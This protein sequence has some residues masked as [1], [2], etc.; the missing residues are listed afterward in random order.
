MAVQARIKPRQAR[1]QQLQQRALELR[2]ARMSYRAIG[3]ELG[4]SHAWARALCEH[5]FR[6]VAERIRAD[7][8][9]ELGSI[10][11]AQDEALAVLHREMTGADT[12]ADRSRAATAFARVLHDRA[13]MLG[14]SAPERTETE[15]M[16][17][18]ERRL[19]STADRASTAGVRGKPL[20]SAS[21]IASYRSSKS[22]YVPRDHHST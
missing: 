22:S 5:A 3:S 11:A 4:M 8:T 7:A 16:S 18:A 17:R 1:K 9:Q 14:L 13:R 20:C 15:G 19:V 21:A 10:L 12:S 6:D 2:A